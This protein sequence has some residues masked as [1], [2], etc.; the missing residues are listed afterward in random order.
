M[1]V[2]NYL[3]SLFYRFWENK[4]GN[5]RIIGS[6]FVTFALVMHMLFLSEVIRSTRLKKV[7]RTSYDDFPVIRDAYWLV[8]AIIV[9]V[10]YFIY[11]PE[12]TDRLQRE[13]E[14]RFSED[15]LGN[16]LKM[17]FYL[18]VPTVVGLYLAFSRERAFF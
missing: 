2:Y 1:N 6:V 9:L 7:V 12:R 13:F 10:V 11:T 8:I 4:I 17:I 5:G 14:V 15:L 18:I 16:I 3:Y